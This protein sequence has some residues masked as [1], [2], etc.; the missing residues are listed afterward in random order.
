MS[1]RYS[2]S[3]YHGLPFQPGKLPLRPILVVPFVLLIAG[4]A[5]LTGWLSW[6]SGQEAIANLVGQHQAEI[7]DRIEEKLATYLETPH[8]I[9][10]L[11]ADAVRRVELKTQDRASERYLWQQIQHFPSLLWIYYGTEP[12]G[13]FV[14]VVRSERA[15]QLAVNDRTTGYEG[16]YYSLDGQGNRRQRIRG[17]G[18]LYDARKRPW[19][20]KAIAASAPSWTQIYP[21]YSLPYL[22]V[23]A[24]LPVYDSDGKLLGVV[25][26][27]LD[28]ANIN[29][30]LNSLKIGKS[31]ETFIIEHSGFLVASST[32]EKPYISNGD[33]DK[34]KRLRATESQAP[35]IRASAN[36]LTQKFG[37][38]HH[39]DIKQKLE[40]EIEGKRQFLQLLPFH[41]RRGID[42]L[43]VVVIPESDFTAQID[44]NRSTTIWLSLVAI[45][46]ASALGIFIARSISRPIRRLTQASQAIANGELDRVVPPAGINELNILSQAFNQM[47]AQ[48]KHSYAEL[49]KTNQE[50]EQRI[51]ERT[52]ALRTSE[53]KFA[54]AFWASPQP[55]SIANRVT[56]Q[57]L[58]VN[59]SYLEYSG[60]SAE[61]LVGKNV[62]ELPLWANPNDPY[63]IGKILDD[64]GSFRNIEI[65]YRKKSGD[66]G[67]V[68]QSAEVVELNGQPCIISLNNDI[69][70]RQRAEAALRQS[71]QQFRTLVA[72]IPGVVYR[73]ADD[74]EWTMEFVGGAVLEVT[75]YPA[76]E[77]I[78]NRV[79]TW[80]SIIYPEDDEMVREV[81][82]EAVVLRQPYI[83]EYRIID[84][85]G[86]I[87][88][89]YDKGQGVFAEDGSLLWLDGALFDITDRKQ[90]ET[91]LLE[92]VH[93]SILT[94]DIGRA[95]T[96]A[97]TIPEML[98]DCA[99]ALW[100]H[101]NVAFARIWTLDA[102]EEVLELQAS[103]GMYTH[104]D[105]DRSR[106][107]VGD[108]KIGQIVRSRQPHLTN[109]LPHD[110]QLGDREWVERE[111]MVAFAGY[112]LLV[113]ERVVGVMAVFA[114]HPLTE[115]ILQ[116]MASVATAIALGI[117]RKRSEEKLQA[118]NA[119]MS[120]LF[121]AMDEIILVGDR[122]GRVLK[123]PPTKRQIRFQPASQL[124]G[125]TLHEFFPPE[126]AALFLSYIRQTLDTQKTLSVE[127]SIQVAGKE[128]WS[129]ANISPIDADSVIWVS[130]DITDRRQAEEALRQ[131][132]SRFQ[133]LA[134]NVPGVIYDL[135]FYTDGSLGLEY[136]SAA[137][138]EICEYEPE[139]FYETP[140]IVLQLVHPDDRPEFTQSLATS[141]QTLEPLA[142]EWRIVTPSGKV[143]WMQAHSRP[144]RR[145]NGDIVR[146]GIIT[147]IT[148]RKQAEQELQLAKQ[149][150]E[151]ANHSK[152]EFL[153]NMSHELRT[154]L[155]VILGFAQLMARNSSLSAEQKSQLQIINRSGEHLL[156]LI[157]DVLEMSRIEAGRL[158]LNETSFDLDRLLD[159]L[160]EMFRLKAN[161]KGL[162]LIFDR[163]PAVPQ[164]IT[165]DESKLRQ[166][167]INLLNN[168]IKF[169]Q[170]GSV[171]LRVRS[172]E[173]RSQK[174][175][176]RSQESGVNFLPISPSPHLPISPSPHLPI[177][178]SP[179][180]PIS[181]LSPSLFFEVEDTG[182][183]IPESEL[184]KVFEAF[185]Q[186]ELGQQ[187]Q[188]GT[189]LGLPISR[190]FV[191]LMGG[192]ITVSSRMGWGTNFKFHVR[193]GL[194]DRTHSSER[195][196]ERCVIGLAPNQPDYR[197]LVVEDRWEGRQL[198]VKL[199]E[200][201][202]F[203]VQAARNGVEAIA[204][205]ESWQPHLI[206]MD[207]RMPV[208]DGY[209]ATRQIKSHPQGRATVIIA[210]TASA[211]EEEKAIVLSAGCDDFVRKPFQ[212]GVILDKVAEHLGVCYLYKEEI[213][214]HPTAADNPIESI[215]DAKLKFYLS[216]MPNTW[217]DRLH[218]AATLADNELIGKLIEEI[219]ATDAALKR[220]LL[221]LVD[222]FRYQHLMELTQNLDE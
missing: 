94:A 133:N 103:A 141:N 84:A 222:D 158:A 106:I 38:F 207:M 181:P 75:G 172:S 101:A 95:L 21:S 41:D 150:A 170:E 7:S 51:E 198:L 37:D 76:E 140:Q 53:E 208:M 14:G 220:S 211:L 64:N 91:A 123:I 52:A 155:N 80:A 72:N 5:G 6:R 25:G 176:V 66:I 16:Y 30:F 44:A 26:A 47:A 73:G 160:S 148:D 152:S 178:P 162:Q 132:E 124:I 146:H 218:Q 117:E 82:N 43:I 35:L 50:L 27:D 210:L 215:S 173:V 108:D 126:Q 23:S 137:S 17:D 34:I 119:E 56:K 74:S 70:D 48:L 202:G 149:A 28:L 197:L 59:Q 190:K 113:R 159:S 203:E 58:E 195:S 99:E 182:A 104:L 217:V 46:G 175:G 97:D 184:E 11:N 55:M 196:P 33:P 118:A 45:G 42:W 60:Y 165:A 49:E 93:V 39:I 112:P 63:R 85:L 193:V 20:Q 153:A 187:L 62:I 107:R 3:Q 131:S 194:S 12:T 109:D 116:A 32:S 216:Q 115:T 139:N 189:G 67:T 212:A 138:R 219:P 188:S 36:Y 13:E 78:Q 164:Y 22:L 121:A 168:A 154:P 77:F 57:V 166:V 89:L 201:V 135:L 145:S 183:G 100:R 221:S 167:L 61:E 134:A 142:H 71:E 96:Q 105:G 129:E 171:T 169:T 88:W 18:K 205:W 54:K 151:A 144:E 102:A 111:Q 191:E 87:R 180:L 4:T 122:N 92:R 130:R 40:F 214:T 114:R 79:R 81:V 19:Y 174:S 128:L 185:V 200:S 9:N 156:Q 65:N 83:L 143:K 120:A 10:Q 86:Q 177:S 161:N 90:I 209:E 31:G 204:I 206:W 8:T 15:L 147:E 98:Q 1:D 110:P 186:T 199:L 127:Y 136:V 2:H 125:K 157:N 179:H 68:L 192:E 24:N 213:I 69:S 163:E 29:D